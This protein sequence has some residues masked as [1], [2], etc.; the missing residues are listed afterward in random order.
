MTTTN[1]EVELLF[2]D[3][4]TCD[5]CQAADRNLDTALEA[6]SGHHPI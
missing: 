6:V 3:L 5:S 2:L 4:D 1:V